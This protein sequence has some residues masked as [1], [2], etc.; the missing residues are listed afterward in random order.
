[1]DKKHED[2]GAVAQIDK[3]SVFQ[4][5]RVFS[6]S[7]ISPRKCRVILTK[8]ALLLFTGENWGRQEA[9]NLFFGISKL[10][11]NKDAALRQ[12]VYLV[13]KELASSA[14]DVIMVTASIMKDV[15]VGSDVV[16]R[17]NAIRALCR[18]IDPSTVQAIER[19]VKTCIVDKNPSVASAA[20]VSSYHLLP[21]AKDVVRRWQSEA[22]EAASGPK[23]GSFLGGFGGSS[24]NALQAS[25]N[26]MTQYHAIG[27]LYQMR[28]GDRMSL[29]KMVQQYSAAG[30]VKSP[31]AT[32]L[33][34]RLAAKLAEEDP[35]LRKPMVQ[36]LDGWLRHKS[37]MVN[38]EAA[39]AICDL[40][41]VTD[42]EL[43]QAV[44][45]LQLFLTSP[46]AVT[47]FAALRILSTMAS[48][49]PDAVRSCNQDIES[50]ITN[51][52]RS[53]ATF[54]I[55]TLLKT[56]NES[57]VDRLMKQITGFMAEITDEFKV[58][59][60][61]AVRTLA[62]K[63]KSKQA[64]FLAFL[65]GILRDEG[66]YEFKR[67]VV[68]AIMDLIRFVPEAKEDALA[69]LCEFIED[70]EFTKL[71]VRI[72]FVL[73]REG[74]STPHPTKYI[75][76][77][78]NRVVLENA[79]VRAAATSAL[80]KFGVGQKDPEI[81]KS[82]HVL[83]SRCLDDVDDE[84]RDRAALNLKLMDQDDDLAISFVRNDSM[85]SLPTLEHQLTMYV[86][87]DSKDTFQDAFDIT[88]IPTVSREQADAADL[89]KKTEGST[90]ILKAPSAQKAPAKT[91]ADAAASATAA[92]QKYAEELQKIPELAAHGGLLKSSAVV[93]L[94]ESETEYVV[95]AV[96][97]IFKDHIV[98]QYDVKNTL[99]D[100]V[101][102]DVEMVVAPED[103]DSGLEEDF[104]IPAAELKTDI[105]GTIYVSFKRLETE[106]Q[107]TATSFTNTLKF[108]SKEIDPSTNEPEDGDGYADE[109]QVED[110][111]LNGADYVT[112][113][114]AG[115]FDNVWEQSNS[116]SATETL[117]LSN[118]KSIVDATEQLIKTLSLQPL[119]GTDVPLSQSTHTLKMYGK[120]I[121]G[122]K[123]AAMVRM[124]FS[125]KTGVTMK[126][127][128]RSEEE[129]V[130]ALVVGSVA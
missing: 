46:R 41:G 72:L 66:G 120:T 129:G 14:D 78:Y 47:K 21:V 74:P 103:D 123:V 5:A 3:T 15:A 70:C 88:K 35:N 27:L 67:A 125:A 4:E 36:L 52:N 13:L 99:P 25:T 107:Y 63:F 87:S 18:V 50:L 54:A 85:Y 91:G 23:S 122:G 60:V 80:A 49:K 62:L 95:T 64:G 106:S 11:S 16:F 48:F 84:V 115:S 75:R 17:P 114:Y 83:L 10:F 93:E 34:V 79:I 1:M 39:K 86:S 22:Q 57:S 118:M 12:M 127:E 100:T 119:E 109:Y 68:E 37:E 77:I 44:H 96:K 101:L 20:L 92:T 105:P 108:V 28:S 117:Q 42:A 124:A 2:V 112:P 126:I 19:L 56:G 7:N 32:V 8:L 94:T 38:F 6:Q 33:L 45:V 30:V 55:T 65:S 73:G 110:L 26:Y 113:A 121:T 89:S 71:A 111:D 61:E 51:S 31:A 29:V 102:L 40:R 128:A 82:V 76:Y 53:I 9:T 104:I 98:L 90:P 59:I 97:H 24:H 58:T 69:T 130:A 43:V 81:K 116:D